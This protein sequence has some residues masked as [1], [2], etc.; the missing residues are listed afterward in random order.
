MYAARAS[1]QEETSC[2]THGAGGRSQTQTV[3]PESERACD[4]L[5][6]RSISATTVQH[7][8]EHQKCSYE[9]WPASDP[10]EV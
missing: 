1:L 5:Q 9:K 7:T 8:L 10:E 3:E 6:E 2:P 4:L